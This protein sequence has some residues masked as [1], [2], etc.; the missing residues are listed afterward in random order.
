[1]HDIVWILYG[2]NTSFELDGFNVIL[3]RFSF[4]IIF[5]I[6]NIVYISKKNDLLKI[7]IKFINK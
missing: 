5:I 3:E 7:N 1:M 6:L 2:L 4:I